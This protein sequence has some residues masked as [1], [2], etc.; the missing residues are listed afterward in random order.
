[1]GWGEGKEKT[2]LTRRYL[3]R[4]KESERASQGKSI[5]GKGTASTKAL[6]WEKSCLVQGTERRESAEDEARNKAGPSQ[7]E[8]S[9]EVRVLA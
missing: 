7:E 3:S 4:T 2:S 9:Q 8:L 1:M 5:L 6:R